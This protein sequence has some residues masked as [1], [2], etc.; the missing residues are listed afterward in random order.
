MGNAA[1]AAWYG[2]HPAWSDYVPDSHQPP[3]GEPLRDWV[4]QGRDYLARTDPKGAERG[5]SF[6][7]FAPK[8][9]DLLFCGVLAPSSDGGKPPRIFPLTIYVPLVRRRYR[10][11]YPLLPAYAA[12]AW[13]EMRLAQQK[14][15]ASDKAAEVE[16][17]LGGLAPAIPAAGWGAWRRFR[18][19]V[20]TVGAADFVGTLHPAGAGPALD[21]LARLAESIAPFRDS[22]LG[23]PTLAFDLPVSSVLK[24]AAYQTAFWLRVCESGL[25][26]QAGQP[27]FF[28][29]AS[30][31][32][33]R[34]SLFLRQPDPADYARVLA[35]VGDPGTVHRLDA[36][37]L[38]VHAALRSGAEAIVN[39]SKSVSDLF[40]AR[41]DRL[42]RGAR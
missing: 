22:R 28:M 2:K 42:L 35:G 17:I 32:G 37:G 5:E 7:L 36:E 39:G 25:G 27:S 10:R 12:Q 14:C 21:L 24:T 41:W 13:D 16:R 6:Y 30:Q 8:E 26:R 15:L 9:T 31:D 23:P 18:R 4:K 38:P 29:H 19:D 33:R 3:D 1:Q 11:A 20:S 34:L 40:K